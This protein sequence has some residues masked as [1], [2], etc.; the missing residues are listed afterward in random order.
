MRLTRTPGAMRSPSFESAAQNRAGRG[1]A[2]WS[3]ASQSPRM[4]DEGIYARARYRTQPTIARHAPRD[5]CFAQATRRGKARTNVDPCGVG[6]RAGEAVFRT[7]LLD[8]GRMI[9]FLLQLLLVRDPCHCQA[10][11]RLVSLL[12]CRIERATH[13]RALWTSTTTMSWVPPT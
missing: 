10:G 5:V 11:R 6:E 12:Q 4:A 3:G 13:L 8:A 2:R 1:G 9:A 7:T